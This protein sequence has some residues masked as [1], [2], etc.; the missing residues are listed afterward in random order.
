VAS[1][2]NKFIFITFLLVAAWSL[3]SASNCPGRADRADT[4]SLPPPCYR[5]RQRHCRLSCYASFSADEYSCWRDQTDCVPT[6]YF[7]CL[8]PPIRE[9]RREDGR[10]DTCPKFRTLPVFRSCRFA[11]CARNRS[12]YYFH[13]LCHTMSHLC[14]EFLRPDKGTRFRTL[15]R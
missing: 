13:C 10:S 11:R 12:H 2:E 3:C 1:L 15:G 4:L 8:C 6:S 5:G 9:L 14:V 7:R